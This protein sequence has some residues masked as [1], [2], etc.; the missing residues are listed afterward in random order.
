MLVTFTPYLYNICLSE[1]FPNSWLCE[2]ALWQSEPNL[3]E[4]RHDFALRCKSGVIRR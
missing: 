1:S 4:A 2:A 3:I